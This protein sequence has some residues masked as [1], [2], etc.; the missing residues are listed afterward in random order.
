MEKYPGIETKLEVI[1]KAEDE[2][3]KL[4]LYG[5]I[6]AATEWDE[7]NDKTF[8]TAKMVINELEKLEGKDVDIHINTRGG[9]ADESIAIRNNLKQYKGKTHVYIDSLAASGGSVIAT[10]ADKVSMYESSRQFIH[11][12][13][14][15]A[16]GNADDLIKVAADL[17]KLDSSLLKNYMSR[18][19]GTEEELKELIKE[20]SILTAEECLTLGFCDEI[21]KDEVNVKQNLLNKYEEEVQTEEQEEIKKEEQEEKQEEV[22]EKKL[23]ENKPKKLMMALIA[24]KDDK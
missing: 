1:N 19:K 16:I 22:K 5:T 6:R 13:W 11:K 15:F 4:Y 7:E 12:G 3:A 23:E 17:E 20:E 9:S 14:T 2:P 24:G 8:I 21:I 18:F 10:G